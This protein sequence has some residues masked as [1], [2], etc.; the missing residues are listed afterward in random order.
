MPYNE[1]E[2]IYG[3]EIKEG[4]EEEISEN[5]GEET[6][7]DIETGDDEDLGGEDL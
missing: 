5:E 7:K 1:D 2:N 4:G 6:E 3:E